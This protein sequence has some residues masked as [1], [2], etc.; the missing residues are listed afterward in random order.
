[1]SIEHN[2]LIR[3][4]S[5]IAGT[6]AIA[7]TVALPLIYFLVSYKYTMGGLETEAEINARNIASIIRSNPDLWKYE[8][9]RLYELLARRPRA[10]HAETRR[11]FD[12][13]GELVAESADRLNPPVVSST[14]P[15]KD[16]GVEVGKIEISRSLAPLLLR[17]GL[18]ALIGIVLGTAVFISLLMMPKKALNE[19]KRAEERMQHFAQNLQEVN[20][21]LKNFA[22]IISHDLRAPL[23]NIKGFTGELQACMQEL[24]SITRRGE[25]DLDGNDGKRFIEILGTDVPEA[26]GFITSS[27]SRMDTLIG[28]VLKLSRLGHRELKP[29]PVDLNELVDGILKT[30][31][32]QLE[33]KNAQ[34]S[35]GT[36][37]EVIQDRVAL[38]QIIGNLLD[39]A[40]KYLDPERPGRLEISAEKT[41]EGYIF[42]F[43]DN[44]RGISLDDQNKV[45]D[46][47]RRAGRQDVQGEGMGLAYVKALVRR[48]D[49]Q[50]WCASEFGEGSTFS[51]SLPLTEDGMGRG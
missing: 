19:L 12:K 35:V 49:G 45:F 48:L 15:L 26:I 10:G 33:Q 36:L 39:N 1:M 23:V 20:E 8:T 41:H 30:L 25:C 51:F 21:E 29:E 46:I 3:I 18:V 50:I 44:G 17:V 38:E 6:V 24:D 37:P 14:Y 7:I 27:V 42:N 11:I 5:C 4:T 16:S 34:V 43:R 22:Y 32:H 40:V 28:L 13:G 9:P 47:F 2:K 31:T